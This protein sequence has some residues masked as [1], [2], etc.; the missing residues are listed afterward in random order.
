MSSGGIIT[1]VVWL[2]LGFIPLIAGIIVFRKGIRIQKGDVQRLKAMQDAIDRDDEICHTYEF[3]A[4]MHKIQHE[5]SSNFCPRQTGSAT[6]PEA[7]SIM[8]GALIFAGGL[9]LCFPLLFIFCFAMDK[10]AH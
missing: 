4:E 5:L 1:I 6:Y 3:Q 2:A 9:V 7:V 10:F 8:G